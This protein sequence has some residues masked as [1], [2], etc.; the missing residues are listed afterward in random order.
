MRQNTRT[1]SLPH[2][3]AYERYSSIIA[4]SI[5]IGRGGKTLI[6]GVDCKRSGRQPLDQDRVAAALK[7]VAIKVFPTA[8]AHQHGLKRFTVY[9]E[10]NGADILR[11]TCPVFPARSP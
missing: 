1:G 4:F 7:L 8:A 6:V 2:A 11:S 3:S 5:A 10:I 9:R